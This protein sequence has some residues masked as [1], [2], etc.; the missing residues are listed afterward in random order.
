MGGGQTQ[1]TAFIAESTQIKSGWDLVVQP[2]P[3]F[4][5]D[6]CVNC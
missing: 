4:G 6:Q 2:A 1:L 5:E 3:D